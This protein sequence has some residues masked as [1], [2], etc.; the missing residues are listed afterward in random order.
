MPIRVLSRAVLILSASLLTGASAA[1]HHEGIYPQVPSLTPDASFAIFSWAGDL[2]SVPASGGAATRLT[3]H[4]ADELASAVSPDGSMIAFE[5]NREGSQNLYVAD[6]TRVGDTLIASTPRRV[7]IADASHNLSGW[8]P[9]GDALLFSSYQE[10]D[11]YREE[12]MYRAPIDGGPVTRL[13]DAF[14]EHPVMSRDGERVVFARGSN[15]TF[16]PKYRGT[17]TGEIWEFRPSTGDFFRITSDDSDD[18]QPFPLPDGSTVFIASSSGQYNLARMSPGGRQPE[19]LTEFQP[20][21][22]PFEG[23]ETIAHGV[24]DLDVSA[25]GSTAIFAV[26]DTL[27]TLDLSANNPTPRAIDIVISGD[28]DAGTATPMDLDRMASE[29]AMSPDGKSIAIVARGEIFVRSTDEG[30]PARR[31]TASEARDQQIAWSPDGSKLYFVSDRDGSEGIYAA[32]VALSRHDIEPED[33]EAGGDEAGDG[34][35]E[36]EAPADDE[37]SAEDEENGDADEKEEKKDKG[38]TPGE[39]WAQS[40]RFAIEPVIVS[41]HVDRYPMPSPDGEELLFIRDRGDI[42]LYD[43]EDD[44]QLMGAVKAVLN[45]GANCKNCC[46]S[47]AIKFWMLPVGVSPPPMPESQRHLR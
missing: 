14:G 29:A 2:W 41:E 26:W 40:L 38:P 24:R 31:V 28:T 1:D 18:M 25:D 22:S 8:T 37:Q 47:T 33:E 3:S 35:E 4:P 39:R 16:R 11:I 9:E 34:E 10:R 23:M 15:T 45:C 12:H 44:E 42:M 19:A 27:F 32:T 6:L 30:R 5:S 36:A 7:T 20:G 46:E 13:T 43:M 21:A 17:A